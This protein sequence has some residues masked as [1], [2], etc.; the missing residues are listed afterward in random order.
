[1][2]ER[3]SISAPMKPRCRKIAIH[4]MKE[5]AM[6]KTPVEPIAPIQVTTRSDT[7]IIATMVFNIGPR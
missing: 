4:M 7:G 3:R 5:E 6:A 1:M 2:A